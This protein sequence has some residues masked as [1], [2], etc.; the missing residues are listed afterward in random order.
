MGSA[1]TGIYRR[2]SSR[3]SGSSSEA[4]GGG[5]GTDGQIGG[6]ADRDKEWVTDSATSLLS[7]GEGK[8]DA[9]R[10]KWHKRSKGEI[11]TQKGRAEKDSR[12]FPV[13]SGW[14]ASVYEGSEAKLKWLD[15]GDVR[16]LRCWFLLGPGARF[17]MEVQQTPR[18]NPELHD[19]WVWPHTTPSSPGRFLIFETWETTD[20]RTI[21]T[22]FSFYL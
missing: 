1:K 21:L 9:E 10:V 8:W 22:D 7:Y 4:G 2:N 3:K 6:Q 5:S 19:D 17:R 15:Q 16:A 20:T 14:I 18:L 13:N 11:K 12:G